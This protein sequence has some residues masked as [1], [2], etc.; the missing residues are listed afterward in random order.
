MGVEE[1]GEARGRER[2]LGGD[3]EGWAREA[4][5]WGELGREEEHE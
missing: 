1:L 5:R 4:V 2:V 3:V